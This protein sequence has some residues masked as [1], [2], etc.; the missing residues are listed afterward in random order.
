MFI[1][2]LIVAVI[3]IVSVYIEL[4]IKPQ[5]TSL[6]SKNV[7]PFAL[8]FHTNLNIV[9]DGNPV[10]IPSQIGIDDSLWKNHTLD[11]YGVPGMPMDEKGEK[12]MLGMAPL[13]TNNNNGRITVGSIVE[14]NYTLQDFLNIWGEIDLSDKKVNAMVDGK[15]VTDYRNIILKDKEQIKL[16]IYSPNK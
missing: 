13:Y 14:R 8:Y 4:A 16:D 10:V 9:I 1:I 6:T 11:K 15:P 3:I 5:N 12:T 2:T 7:N